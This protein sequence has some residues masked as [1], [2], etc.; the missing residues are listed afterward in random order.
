MENPH[1]R[2]PP[3]WLRPY[4][5]TEIPVSNGEPYCQT[6]TP[7]SDGEPPFPPTVRQR[8]SC[9]KETPIGPIWES[10]PIK[11]RP[12]FQTGILP[13]P[14]PNCQRS[15]MET[16]ISEREVTPSN[17]DPTVRQGSSPPLPQLPVRQSSH[18]P[19]SWRMMATK[20]ERHCGNRRT[21]A[22]FVHTTQH[23][24]Q[25]FMMAFGS[26]SSTIFLLVISKTNVHF[27]GTKISPLAAEKCSTRD[28]LAIRTKW[29]VD[30][31]IHFKPS[32]RQCL[33]KLG[34]TVSGLFHGL[35]TQ[36]NPNSSTASPWPQTVCF[37]FYESFSLTSMNPAR[38]SDTKQAVR[39]HWLLYQVCITFWWDKQY[40][41][42]RNLIHITRHTCPCIWNDQAPS[43]YQPL[44][45]PI[46][47]WKPVTEHEPA[48]FMDLLGADHW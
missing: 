27:S 8:S 6:G 45:S 35:Y 14:T 30:L 31:M 1:V 42:D 20:L 47:S 41:T 11:W 48:H 34:S 25:K 46:P 16:P 37:Q 36:N 7:L 22:H 23:P 33:V 38:W 2:D 18:C 9:Q 43:T 10:D 17:G 12:H 19:T 5:Q 40:L 4:C 24:R 44:A 3:I 29:D 32:G 21:Q 13:T 28:I 15:Q 39:H 26:Q